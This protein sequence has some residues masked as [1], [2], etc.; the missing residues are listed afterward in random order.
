MEA[1]V[2]HSERIQIAI[3][4]IDL[5]Q[6][7]ADYTLFTGTGQAVLVESLVI[8]MPDHAAGGALTGI[9]IQTND[10]TAIEFISAAAGVV[11]NLTAEAQLA[12][13]VPVVVAVGTLI[14]LTIVGGA[15]GAEH[16]CTVYATYRSLVT[17][18]TLV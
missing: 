13:S 7:A 6:V 4:T 17:G 11:A 12:S 1:V 2:Q 10:S 8:R 3:T 15:E 5:N 18:G 16:I 14:E 9:S